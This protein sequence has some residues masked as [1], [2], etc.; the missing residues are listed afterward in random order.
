MVADR[1]SRQHQGQLTLASSGDYHRRTRSDCRWVLILIGKMRRFEL[2]A[3]VAASLGAVLLTTVILIILDARLEAQHLVIGYL[4][5][6]TV[7][8]VLFGST[9]AFIASA[10]SSIAAAY[11]LFPPKFSLYIASPLHIAELG[12]FVLLA[13]IASKATAVLTHDIQTGELRVRPG[14]QH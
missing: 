14:G 3:P 5:P 13:I 10:I 12:F 2:I 9:T 8:A 7:I 4:F 1:Q 11:F 6:T